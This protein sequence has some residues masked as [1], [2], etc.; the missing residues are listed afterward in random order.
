MAENLVTPEGRKI[1]APNVKEPPK[2]KEQKEALKK[3]YA[4]IKQQKMKELKDFKAAQKLEDEKMKKE[5]AALKQKAGVTKEQINDLMVEQKII[6]HRM[7]NVCERKEQ[8]THLMLD[9]LVLAWLTPSEREK[10]KSRKKFVSEVVLGRNLYLM[11][12]PLLLSLTF[13]DYLTLYGL[14]IAFKDYSPFI[15]IWESPWAPDSGLYYF[16]S[17]LTG[18]FVGRLFGNTLTINMYSILFAFPLP[19]IFALL[20]N[21]L[22]SK[23][24]KTTI[25]TLSYL[26]HFVSTVVIAGLVVNFLSPSTGI[27]NLVYKKITGSPDGIYF[28]ADPKYF[29]TIF[30]TMNAW[31]GVGFAS[32]IYASTLVSIDPELYEA[33]RIDGAGRWKQLLHITLPGL[34]PTVSIMLILRIGNVL[35]VGYEAIILLYQPATYVVADV[36]STYVYRSGIQEGNFSLST[37]VGLFNGIIAL[38]LVLGANWA[39]KKVSSVGLW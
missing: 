1:K 5:L 34:L 24:F 8:D 29:R 15:G 38:F 26:P 36:I 22:R 17:F 33:A 2:P 3:E 7:K 23:N 10:R 16:K 4:V 37:A 39:S 18:P 11:L 20:L 27:I 13:F 19:I 35:S 9:K 28:L 6:R 32:I 31:Q 30:I 14:Q 25:Q 12:V 21:E